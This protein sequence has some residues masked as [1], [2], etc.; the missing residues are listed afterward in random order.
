MTFESLTNFT[1]KKAVHHLL[2]SRFRYNCI[3]GQRRRHFEFLV[4]QQERIHPNLIRHFE[5]KEQSGQNPHHFPPSSRRQGPL[6]YPALRRNKTRALNRKRV[7][8]LTQ[9]NGDARHRQWG[10]HHRRVF[11]CGDCKVVRL[12]PTSFTCRGEPPKV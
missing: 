5:F 10:T 3:S 7:H 6:R 9:K 8:R 4:R 2:C 11:P 12:E 1:N